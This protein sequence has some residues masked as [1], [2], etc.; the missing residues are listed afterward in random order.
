MGNAVTYAGR[1][2]SAPCGNRAG[3]LLRAVGL[4][5]GDA[6]GAVLGALLTITVLVNVLFMQSGS[7]PAPMFKGASLQTKPVIATHTTSA[8]PPPTPER[9]RDGS[10][11]DQA[12]CTV[13]TAHWRPRTVGI[14]EP[15]H[16]P[17]ASACRLRLWADQGDRNHR[18][19]YPGSH[20]AIRARAQAADHGPGFRPRRARARGDDRPTA[21]IRSRRARLSALIL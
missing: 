19:R 4:K 11:A 8:G 17:A 3:S 20:R 6:L 13:C 14:F 2:K 18:W 12:H 5:A 16:R 15:R 10:S 9:A 7:H 21:G 1:G